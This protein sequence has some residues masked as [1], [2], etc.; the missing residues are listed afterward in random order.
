MASL[1]KQIA[2]GVQQAFKA[3]G[4]VAVACVY[5]KINGQ[6]TVDIVSG[7]PT[8]NKTDYPLPRV[9]FTKHK[10]SDS[11]T[12]DVTSEDMKVLF[13]KA[14]MAA[15]PETTDYLTDPDGRTWEI[16]QVYLEPS[17]T[18]TILRVRAA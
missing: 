12:S 5:S 3:V 4:D 10:E 16:K 8:I 13:P 18:L 11:D 1:R 2:A 14:D 9:V 7:T 15:E 17:N 6:P